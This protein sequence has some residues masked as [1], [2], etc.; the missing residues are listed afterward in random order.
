M[1]LPCPDLPYR[2]IAKALAFARH[3]PDPAGARPL[4]LFL[5]CGFHPAK[6]FD[7]WYEYDTWYVRMKYKCRTHETQ[8]TKTPLFF[9]KPYRCLS[10]RYCLL[11]QAGPQIL[12]NN[13][14]ALS[15]SPMGERE[16][17]PHAGGHI[18]LLRA[19]IRPT[20]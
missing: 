2:L 8:N 20:V 19:Q 13:L 5:A 16:N 1:A 17:Y 12:P 3:V 10:S 9:V 4:L 7:T 11:Y 18:G 6:T 15:P 14:V